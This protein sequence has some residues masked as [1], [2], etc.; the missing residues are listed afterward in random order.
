MP[1]TFTALESAIIKII[2]YFDIFDYPLNKREIHAYL[3]VF[4]T[5]NELE[6]TLSLL[7]TNKIIISNENYYFAENNKNRM[8]PQHFR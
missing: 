1:N 7:K 4:C 3:S 6:N 8:L 2:L 5:E